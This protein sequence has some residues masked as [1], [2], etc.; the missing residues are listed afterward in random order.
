VGESSLERDEGKDYDKDNGRRR[1]A[2]CIP[3]CLYHILYLNLCA[4]TV[5]YEEKDEDKDKDERSVLE[6]PTYG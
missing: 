3:L 6:Q 5:R 2:G 4:L 1:C